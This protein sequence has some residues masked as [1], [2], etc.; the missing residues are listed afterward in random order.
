VT[1][2]ERIFLVVALATI[3]FSGASAAERTAEQQ[4]ACVDDALSF[5]LSEV[6]NIDRIAACMERNLDK[7]SPPCRAQVETARKESLSERVTP[8]FIPRPSKEN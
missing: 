3:A 8:S 6:P 1:R 7:L 4:R 5:C 2:A